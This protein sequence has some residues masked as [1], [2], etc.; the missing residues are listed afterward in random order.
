MSAA[1]NSHVEV[2][3]MLISADDIDIDITDNVRNTNNPT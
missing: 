3:A 1:M 2:V